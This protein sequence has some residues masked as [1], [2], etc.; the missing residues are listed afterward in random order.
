MTEDTLLL[1]A[2]VTQQQEQNSLLKTMLQQQNAGKQA[3]D[4]W[5]QQNQEL[6]S[7]C[8]DARVKLERL[9]LDFVEEMTQSLAELEEEGYCGAF[10]TCEFLDKYGPRIQQFSILSH[11]LIN[12][13]GQ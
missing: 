2:M 3:N 13:G 11:F 5:R 12:L 10:T 8:K 6:A 4:Q 7:A 9:L 1:R